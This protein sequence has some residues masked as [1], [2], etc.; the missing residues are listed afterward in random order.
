M[1]CKTAQNGIKDRRVKAGYTLESFASKMDVIPNTV[2]RWEAGEREPS[3]SALQK[4]AQILKCTLD[5]LLNP[6]KP[7]TQTGTKRKSRAKGKKAA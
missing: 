6:P 3:L 4:M 5:E 1:E 2:W 7:S